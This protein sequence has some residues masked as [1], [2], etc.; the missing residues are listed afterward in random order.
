VQARQR[1]LGEPRSQWLGNAV[2]GQPL[3]MTFVTYRKLV[4][5]SRA[6]SPA[7]PYS[8]AERPRLLGID[9]GEQPL[10]RARGCRT[11]WLVQVDR[12]VKLLADQI[13]L[14]RQFAVA[15]ERLLHAISV[16]AAQRPGRVP[17]QQSFYLV[18]LRL[19]VYRVHGQPLSI[20]SE[21][22]SSASRLRA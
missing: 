1:V 16:A 3:T 4:R 13:I 15:G 19:F 21:L 22:S 7:W 10:H 12:L 5:D 6:V 14:P 17:R 11:E 18:R 2:A 8:S 9:G 20:P